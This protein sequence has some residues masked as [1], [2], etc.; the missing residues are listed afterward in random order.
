MANILIVENDLS[1][2][3]ELINVI[4]KNNRELRLSGIATTVNDALNF[5]KNDCIDIILINAQIIKEIDIKYLNKYKNS[6]IILIDNNTKF[7]SKYYIQTYQTINKKENIDILNKK[8]NEL[9]IQSR[10]I[11][12]DKNL[13]EIIKDELI[14]LEYNPSYKGFEYLIETIFLLSNLEG[15]SSNSLLKNIYPMVAKKFN[16][17]PLNIKYDIRNA[18]EMMCYKCRQSKLSNYLG[19]DTS[20]KPKTKTIIC[21]IAN[22]IR[23]KINKS[24]NLIL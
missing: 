22:N 13:R 17:S 21:A 5:I 20:D 12:D 4:V 16:T 7:F 9:I 8:L 11:N 2:C 23:K 10:N 18:T 15:Y 3:I 6:I 1:Y 24:A 14:Y 19:F